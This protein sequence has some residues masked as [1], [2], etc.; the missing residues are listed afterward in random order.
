MVKALW[1]TNL[2]LLNCLALSAGAHPGQYATRGVTQTLPYRAQQNTLDALMAIVAWN[3]NSTNPWIAGC[4]TH[5]VVTNPEEAPGQVEFVVSHDENVIDLTGQNLYLRNMTRS[6]IEGLSILQNLDG[7][8]YG[9]PR[10]FAFFEDFLDAWIGEGEAPYTIW[11][12]VKDKSYDPLTGPSY[13]AAQLV[14]ALAKWRVKYLDQYKVDIFKH[15]IMSSDNPFIGAALDQE[16]KKL[17]LEG[18]LN[19]FADYSDW[20]LPMSWWA[21]FID[22]KGGFEELFDMDTRWVSFENTLLTRERVARNQVKDKQVIGWGNITQSDPLY[23]LL[24]VVLSSF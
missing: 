13:T 12:N 1:L 4:E 24:N 5:V 17:G 16:S 3:K 7:I 6:D 9:R 8:D 14:P 21:E 20:G 23:Q 11:L 15:L 22:D 10:P 18:V 19:I 2:L